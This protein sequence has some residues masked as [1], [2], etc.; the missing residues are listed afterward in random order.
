ML[1]LLI[2]GDRGLEVRRH[3]ARS[4]LPLDLHRGSAGWHCRNH[5][6][7]PDPLRRPA[8]A[9]RPVVRDRPRDGA[10]DGRNQQTLNSTAPD[11]RLFDLG[12]EV[13][14]ARRELSDFE[15]FFSHLR[16]ISINT[17]IFMKVVC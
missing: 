6:T 15:P 2:L 17:R 7:S 1:Q 13:L 8:A 10:T 9:R 11:L 3:G 12:P 14:E 5:P 16:K 4:P